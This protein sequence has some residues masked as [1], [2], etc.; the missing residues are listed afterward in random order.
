MYIRQAAFVDGK[1][2]V[3]YDHLV[4]DLFQGGLRE[5]CLLN[6]IEKLGRENDIPEI[7]HKSEIEE[8]PQGS[9]FPQCP[10]NSW[11]REVV[12]GFHQFLD[13]KVS[14]PDSLIPIQIGRASCRE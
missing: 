7:S 5:L 10:L 14:I 11:L 4:I 8:G 13:C 6:V 1:F 2:Q 3:R 9:C 12:R